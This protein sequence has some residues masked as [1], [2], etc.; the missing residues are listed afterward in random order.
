[1]A[2]MD[3]GG[4]QGSALRIALGMA[5]FTI[6]VASQF[7]LAAIIDHFGFFGADIRQINISRLFGIVIM[8]LGIWLTIR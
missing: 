8:F 3:Q 2:Y 7:I 1:M 5:A 6:I 4:I